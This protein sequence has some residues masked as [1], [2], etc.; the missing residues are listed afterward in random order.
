M[1]GTSAQAAS[2]SQMQAQLTDI[3]ATIQSIQQ[4]LF[5]QVLGARTDSVSGL[6]A[7]Y[8]M[9]STAGSVVGNPTSV[10][11]VEG[12]G[13]YAF[14]GNDGFN[15]GTPSALNI[16]DTITFSAW[17]NLTGSQQSGWGRVISRTNGAT[18]EDWGMVVSNSNELD[19]RVNGS[20]RSGHTLSTNGWQHVACTYDGSTVRGYV[21][22]VEVFS[23]NRSGALSTDQPVA[24]GYN[25]TGGATR[26]FIG[27]IDDVRVYD[28]ALSRNE[29][30][31]VM[32]AE[33]T[34]EPEPTTDP[35]PES[36]PTPDPTPTSNGEVTVSNASQLNT[37]I[38]NANG[39]ETIVLANGNY[40][41]IDIND[42]FDSPVTIKS[43]NR[44]QAIFDDIDVPG[45]SYITLDGLVINSQ[46]RIDRN[47][48]HIT[49]LDSVHEERFVLT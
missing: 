5:G 26:H 49:I 10:S 18:A 34:A 2:N 33:P 19:C 46:P 3:A 25:V 29:V 13:A 22:G 42:N 45:G 37:A 30:E 6:A 7:R 32:G 20:N 11:G 12:S 1:T 9:D 23:A 28:E 36:D 8:D 39:G 40:G 43:A 27:Q 38:D 21:D 17:I 24:I 31:L 16:T 41:S 44:H 48:H 47:A 14:D 35:E 4:R 15:L